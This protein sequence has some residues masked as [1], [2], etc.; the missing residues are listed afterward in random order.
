M[1][2]ITC[3][4]KTPSPHK[5]P[6]A[7]HN[8]STLETYLQHDLCFPKGCDPFTV[9]SL[10]NHTTVKTG[11]SRSSCHLET[12]MWKQHAANTPSC[13]SFCSSTSPNPCLELVYLQAGLRARLDLRPHLGKVAPAPSAQDLHV[14]TLPGR[15][16]QD[17]HAHACGSSCCWRRTR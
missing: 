10:V 15:R 1:L 4:L 7:S 16:S 12:T 8:T 3:L 5:R 6:H 17:S 14:I 9:P 2:F 13:F 11:L